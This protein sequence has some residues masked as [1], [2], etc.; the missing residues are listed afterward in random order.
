MGRGPLISARIITAL[1]TTSD[2]Y[3]VFNNFY[4]YKIV[5]KEHVSTITVQQNFKIFTSQW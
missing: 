4:I 3:F 1:E 2:I 5:Y